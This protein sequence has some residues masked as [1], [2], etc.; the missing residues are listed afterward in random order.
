MV[1]DAVCRCGAG[2]DFR[3][4][5]VVNDEMLQK[6]E[7]LIATSVTHVSA[8]SLCDMSEFVAVH[9]SIHV[10]ARTST[11]MFMQISAFMAVHMSTHMSAHI[12]THICTHVYHHVCVAGHPLVQPYVE[13]T[14]RCTVQY[15][16]QYH[17]EQ[18]N[19]MVAT[20]S[21]LQ[22]MG[23]IISHKNSPFSSAQKSF[24]LISWIGSTCLRIHKP[25]ETAGFYACATKK[26][27]ASH[28]HKQKQATT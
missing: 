17:M 7:A 26:E 22:Y 12:S 11:L 5:W 19:R 3:W 9:M 6:P 20:S 14:C 1:V 23:N 24:F 25:N 18:Y 16:G 2:F 21:S 4:Q 10:S 27:G 8:T 28:S 13:C 15:M